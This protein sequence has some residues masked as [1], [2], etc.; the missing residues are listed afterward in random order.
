MNTNK[1]TTLLDCYHKLRLDFETSKKEAPP[2]PAQLWLYQEILYRIQQLDALQFVVNA[3][4]LSADLKTIWPHYKVVNMML[5][6]TRQE[7]FLKASKEDAQKEQQAATDSLSAVF[8]DYKKR[9]ANYAPASPEQYQK[10]IEKT[11]R[12]VLPAWITYRDS[13]TRIRVD[14]EE[15]A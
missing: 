7:R 11:V 3:A 10:D 2:T 8:D 1:K 9:F 6:N 13:I 4:P 14:I 15:A 5:E 12:T